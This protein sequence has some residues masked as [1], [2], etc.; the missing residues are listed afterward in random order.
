MATNIKH[1]VSAVI[2]PASLLIAPDLSAED[3]DVTVAMLVVNRDIEQASFAYIDISW[4]NGWS[5]ERNNDAAWVF[6]KA[7]DRGRYRHVSVS[8]VEVMASA[9]REA[10]ARASSDGRGIWI[11]PSGLFRGNVHVRVKVEFAA[12][13]S[14][15]PDGASIEAFGIEMVRI[16]DGAFYAGD[17]SDSGQ[18]FGAFY[19]AGKTDSERDYFLVES[20][21]PVRIGPEEGNLYYG[22]GTYLGDRGG[23]LPQQFPKG[24]A[25]FY[26]MKY[27]MTQGQ[28][29]QMLNTLPPDQTYQRANFMVRSYYSNRG[30][31]DLVDGRFVAGSPDRPMNYATWDDQLAFADWA[32]LRPMTEL[33]FEKAARGPDKPMAGDFPW[34][35]NDRS[36][37]QRTV[38]M[39]GN[40]VTNGY[41]DESALTSEAL[42]QFGA[43]Y[44]RVMDLAGSVWERV[45]TIGSPHGRAFEGSHGDGQLD[46]AAATN[47]D[48][49]IMAEG[50][51]G[52]GYRGGGYYGSDFSAHEFNPF[53]PVAYRRFGG[54]SGGSPHRAYGF[55]AV[56]SD[57]RD[58]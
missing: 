49:P 33:E 41:N 15:L 32:A 48:W 52:H 38:D 43:S 13:D 28:Y 18:L 9:G 22:E 3:L 56:R 1:L 14:G 12:G 25:G 27:E 29:V 5:D 39:S 10:V 31:I 58:R 7:N 17:P 24:T 30:T 54:W 34:G 21:D 4:S 55:R 45:I 19:E 47:T 42:A 23:T 50:R 16:P 6:L 26:I 46:G 51:E 8:G 53:S 37:L 2:I 40:T 44:Y 36:M 57:L 20:E 35:T 11:E